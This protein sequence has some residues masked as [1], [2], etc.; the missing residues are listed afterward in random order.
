[1]NYLLGD[2]KI[3]EKLNLDQVKSYWHELKMTRFDSH[4]YLMLIDRLKSL[5][6]NLVYPAEEE[7]QQIRNEALNLALWE[8]NW[9]TRN[10][11][12]VKKGGI[13]YSLFPENENIRKLEKI[14]DNN[15]TVNG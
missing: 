6:P 10:R 7:L 12:R 3:V 1:M 13:D 9:E 4:F 5:N 2:D 15:M 8:E 14:K 11:E